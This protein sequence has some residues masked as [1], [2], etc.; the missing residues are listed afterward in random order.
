MTTAAR[1]AANSQHQ[2]SAHH[3]ILAWP[4]HPHAKHRLMRLVP[5][6]SSSFVL[7]PSP[8]LLPNCTYPIQENISS[9]T[10]AFASTAADGGDGAHT[11]S[12][13]DSTTTPVSSSTSA[14]YLQV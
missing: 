10:R 6:M 5:P 4:R 11:A 12:R 8:P 2:M 1:R 14:R 13:M 3:R 9:S 7:I